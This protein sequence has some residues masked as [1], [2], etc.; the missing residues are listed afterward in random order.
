MKKV[1]I[2]EGYQQ[3]TPYLIV[4][5]A[6]A[7]IRFTQNVFDATEKQKH[8]RD[9][10]VIM[11]AEIGIGESVIMVADATGQYKKSPAGLF[12]YVDDCDA[13][14]KKGL[15]NGATT[16]TEPADQSYGRSAGFTDPFGNTWWIT[17]I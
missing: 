3:L 6:P 9:E 1:N 8:M 16:A 12:L 2:P 11:H 15:A 14:Y 13:V 4:E 17:S 7:F 10:K 5:D